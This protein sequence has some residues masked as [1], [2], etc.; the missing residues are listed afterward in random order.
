MQWLLDHA[1]VG[2]AWCLIHATH[3]DAAETAGLARSGAV[4][5]LCPITE[6]NLGDGIFPARAYL[7]QGGRVALGTDSHILID[8]AGELRAL[9]YSQRLEARARNLLARREGASVG[10]SLFAGARAG[11]ARALAVEP[12]GLQVGAAA[13]IV[14][15]DMDHP[16]LVERRGDAILDAWIFAVG[17]EAV[18]AVWRA[19]KQVVADGRH[20]NASPIAARYRATLR[21]LLDA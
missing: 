13:D 19:G 18:A 20:R 21:R 16:A 10:A 15:L 7:D 1:P 9:E 2:S 14:A 4:A 17:R 5:G 8:A 6:A 11:G 3:L 12:A